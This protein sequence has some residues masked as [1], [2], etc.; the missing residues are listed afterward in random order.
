MEIGSKSDGDLVLLQVAG[1]IDAST[2]PQVEH[3]VT[4]AIGRGGRRL[5]FDMRD[6]N[7]ISSAGLRAILM[8]AKQAKSASG[9]VA[10]FGLQPEVA[11][12]FTVSGFGKIVPVAGSEAE[13]RNQLGG[14][15]G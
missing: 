9:A 11:E 15:G 3:A 5:I 2:S 12:V 1:S 6:V 13:A 14:T 8:A 7:Y 10:V 4:V